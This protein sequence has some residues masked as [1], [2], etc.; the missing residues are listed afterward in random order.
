[1]EN[2]KNKLADQNGRNAYTPTNAAYMRTQ[3]RTQDRRVYEKN[4]KNQFNGN[5]LEY[6]GRL[7]NS[8]KNY[9]EE[10]AG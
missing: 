3:Q 8:A 10:A 7:P 5:K 1:M 9:R 6:P 4:Q 2:R